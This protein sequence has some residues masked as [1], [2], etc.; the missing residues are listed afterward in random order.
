MAAKNEKGKG[1]GILK[2][3]LP[4]LALLVALL[5]AIILWHYYHPNRSLDFHQT[6]VSL[7]NRL[8]SVSHALPA[9]PN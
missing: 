9:I 6:H 1:K 3:L 8:P 7:L 5:F 4:L 2:A